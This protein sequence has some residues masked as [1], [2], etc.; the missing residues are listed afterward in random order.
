M[1]QR[2]KMMK[3]NTFGGAGFFRTMNEK[4]KKEMKKNMRNLLKLERSLRAKKRK[5]L[6]DTILGS[7]IYILKWYVLIWGGLWIIEKL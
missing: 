6:H 4:Q 7:I 2:R 3:D 5:Y 1:Y